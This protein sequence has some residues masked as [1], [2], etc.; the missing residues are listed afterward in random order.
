MTE[1]RLPI[2]PYA[3]LF[4]PMGHPEFDRL[5]GDIA[6]N[7]LQEPIVLHEGKVLEGRN[8]YL[9]CLARRVPEL[10]EAVAAAK[11][12]V[13]AAARIA[14]LPA[15]QQRQVL[16]QVQSGVKPKEALARITQARPEQT[17]EL[18]DEGGLAVPEP[19][20]PAFQQRK[21]L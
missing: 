20:V 6:V 21:T 4:P 9:A 17:A 13:S 18:L 14:G 11:L 12:A 3:E 16:L 5:C 1:T 7:G 10:V 15:E 8:R 19:A 2:H